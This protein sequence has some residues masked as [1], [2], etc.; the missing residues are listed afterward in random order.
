LSISFP[1]QGFRPAGPS[2]PAPSGD[3]SA[4]LARAVAQLQW[5]SDRISEGRLEDALVGFEAALGFLPSS[6]QVLHSFGAL[7]YSLEKHE[8]AIERFNQALAIK[9]DFIDARVHLGRALAALGRHDEALTHFN[10]A[11]ASTP[12]HPGAHCYASISLEALNRPEPALGHAVRSVELDPESAE[13]Q[14]AL[15]QILVVHGRME[16]AREA[17]RQAMRLAPSA[18]LYYRAFG[19]WFG[20][21]DDAGALARLQALAVGA[22]A[23]PDSDLMH[24]YFALHKALEDK[25]RWAEAF[26]YL[27][28][29]NAIQRRRTPYD[30]A[31]G[32]G[33]MERVCA[34][35]GLERFAEFPGSGERSPK[36]IFIVGMPRSGTTLVEQLLAAHPNVAAGGELSI[37]REVVMAEMGASSD[38]L[39]AARL[40]QMGRRYIDLVSPIAPGAQR[41]TD[42]MP[43][44]FVLIGMIRLILPQASIIHVRRDPIDT[45]LSCFSK[46]FTQG[47]RFAN[48]LGEL[49]RYYR[50]YRA[51]MA[52]WRRVLPAGAMLEVDY[53]D[54]VSDFQ[55]QAARILDYC[56]LEWSPQCLAFDKAERPVRTASAAQV[57]KP[58]YTTSVGRARNYGELLKPLIEALGDLEGR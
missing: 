6:P 32:L 25:G 51:L 45:C 41:I 27:I 20:F 48:D 55:P 9:P 26:R 12:D 47:Q 36:P 43:G 4:G 37:L 52:H 11:L 53:E 23:L 50:S 57:R 3:A 28:K 33:L 7:L 16:P 38:A 13:A 18:P 5:A 49:G 30:E 56:G 2:G 58:I 1:S 17:M 54:L 31:E 35:F 42:K 29:A 22:D 39:D 21:G 34:A 8:A 44:N 46:L 15:G 24:L 40:Q 10:A 14:F 19:D